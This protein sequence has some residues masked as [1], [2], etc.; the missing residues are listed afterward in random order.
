MGF[1]RTH[2]VA[3]LGLEG[4]LVDVEADIGASLPSFVLLGLPDA[5]LMESRER[6]RSAA[7]N[8]GRALAPRRITVN[9]TPAT[10]PKTGSG[11]DLAIVMAAVQADGATE[12]TGGCVYLAELGLDGCL[13]PV[14]GVFPSVAAAVATGPVTADGLVEA[15]GGA[16]ATLV[17]DLLADDRIRKFTFTGLAVPR[18]PGTAVWLSVFAHR[19][20]RS[21]QIFSL[22]CCRSPLTGSLRQRNAA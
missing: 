20:R 21:G 5:T 9:L 22:K 4:H 10:L 15:L 12:P 11:Y 7:K 16:D 17:S 18:V 3:L 13:R 14:P 2:T 8:S 19:K 6:I 1:A